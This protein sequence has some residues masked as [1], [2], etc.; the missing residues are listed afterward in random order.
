[1]HYEKCASGV[2]SRAY[3]LRQGREGHDC[4]LRCSEELVRR[5]QRFDRNSLIKTLGT[6]G[7]SFCPGGNFPG[8]K[9]LA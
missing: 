9:Q 7:V 1:M 4:D 5:L 6:F 8:R 3:Q 2:F